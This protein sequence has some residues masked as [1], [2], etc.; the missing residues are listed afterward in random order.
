MVIAIHAAR[1]ATRPLA[2]LLLTV[3]ATA[4]AQP[5]PPPASLDLGEVVITA[6][7]QPPTVPGS[8]TTMGAPRMQLLDID[9]LSTG[10]ET[11][12][13]ADVNPGNRG[14]ARNE[15]GVFIRGFDQSRVPL[16]LD[17]I[18]VYVPYDGYVDLNRFLTGDIARIEIA[19]G[20]TSVLYGPG[21]LGAVINLIT[22]K[23]ERAFEGDASAG[24][25]LDSAGNYQGLRITANLGSRQGDWF[26]QGS[27]S[28][29]STDHPRLPGTFGGGLYQRP[30]NRL[31]SNE[32][33]FRVSGKLGYAPDSENEYVLGFAVARANKGAPPYAGWDA[34]RATFFDWPYY[35]K[36]SI[37]LLTRT[38]LPVGDNTYLRT[39]FY[40]D[41]F[42][43]SLYR[44]DNQFY[45]TQLRPFAFRSQY[46][47]DSFG[48]SVEAGTEL[49]TGNTTR[50]AFHARQDTHREFGP[51]TP[52]STMQDNTFSIAV[53]STQRLT[54]Q[55]VLTFG[56]SEDIRN[57]VSAQDPST[58]G[59][60][61]FVVKDQSATNIQ[62]GLRY[63]LD[64]ETD[65]YGSLGR[66]ARFATMFERY[67]YR[68][69]N[70]IPNPGLKPEKAT[71]A[72]I[73]IE[74]RVIPDTELSVALF[75]N[76]VDDYIQ[77]VTVGRN[78]APPFNSIV[79]NQ[80]VG[81]DR[82]NGV[83]VDLTTRAIPRTILGANY[84]FLLREPRGSASSAPYYGTPRHKAFIYAQI[85]LGS[86][87]S[88]V[89]SMLLESSRKTTDTGNGLPVQGFVLG[90]IKG[91][92]QATE[93]ISV[94][95][96]VYNI[97]DQKYQYDSGYPLPGRSYLFTLR[98]RF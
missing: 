17:G 34:T 55:L 56:V 25:A 83:D 13:G 49:F 88:V 87:F 90:N 81:N 30:G 75:N 40:Y 92:Y 89:P 21:A 12:P 93:T 2:C 46:D 10:L 70:G 95:A 8:I 7:G 60:T 24:V 11:L 37:Y 41:S 82:F 69:G 78:P 62:A 84:T 76:D 31:R 29:L 1:A 32:Q 4:F 57:P 54:D 26:A 52:R 80:N 47:D 38:A 77:T 39:R 35:D 45:T 15:T 20:Y 27:F 96:A 58:G 18:P 86:G 51:S 42:R 94:E 68:L 48:G 79:Q 19:K 63:A 36:D 23:P 97:A 72:E 43:N 5:I 85:D 65:L 74:T 3:S 50:V 53:E 61:S 71:K 73:G 91:I 22:R 14:G 44:Y 9:R 16:L 64:S 6:P 67:S 33:D 28:E 66:R 98:T 59:R